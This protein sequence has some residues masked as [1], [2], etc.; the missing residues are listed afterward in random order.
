MAFFFVLLFNS[1]QAFFAS[2]VFI[3]NCPIFSDSSLPY[4]CNFIFKSLQYLRGL[5]ESAKTSITSTIEKYHSSVSSSQTVRTFFSSNNFIASF[6]V[7]FFFLSRLFFPIVC[8][9]FP[10]KTDIPNSWDNRSLSSLEGDLGGLMCIKPALPYPA[11]RNNRHIE[12]QGIFHFFDNDFPNIFQFIF[13][14]GKI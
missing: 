12:F 8:R 11:I 3:F 9:G 13:G 10:N 1:K 5:S 4:F 6:F 14:Y 7:M 2:R